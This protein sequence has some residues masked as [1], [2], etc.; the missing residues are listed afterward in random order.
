MEMEQAEWDDL[1]KTVV[2]VQHGFEP[3]VVFIGRV[4]VFAHT[5]DS[6]EFSEFYAFSHDADLMISVGEYTDLKDI[7]QITSNKNLSKSQFYKGGVEFD[8]YVEGQHKLPVPYDEVV[9]QSEMRNGVRVACLEH[10]VVLKIAA[11]KDR[12]GSAK[13]DKDEDDLIKI[14]M[15]LSE[16]EVSPAKAARVDD[17]METL[18]ELIVGSD[19]VTRV[20]DGNLHLASIL[21][22][23]AAVGLDKLSQARIASRT[24]GW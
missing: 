10:L 21:R 18:L 6:K 8:V 16:R 2:E 19:S 12:R 3:S 17:E 9:S 24:L 4:A 1:W 14:L 13:G 20:A 11:F 15:L 23:S 5:M 22:K 7:E